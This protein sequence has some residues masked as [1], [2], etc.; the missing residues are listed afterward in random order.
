M[1][2]IEIKIVLV[3]HVNRIVEV[4]ALKEFTSKYFT[5]NKY[6][7]VANL[8]PP[9]KADGFLDIVY[10]KTE[11][12][13]LLENVSCAGICVGIMNYSFDDNF[14]M[15]RVGENKM[16][17]SLSKIDS[18]LLQKDISIENFIIKCIYEA[19]VLY[20][21]FGTLTDDRIY[22]FI[23]RDT[24]GCLFDLNGD[25]GDVIYN[26]E[27]PIICDECKSKI[28]RGSIPVGLIESIG[29]ELK[30]IHKPWVKSA[31]LFIK[32]YPLISIISTIIL[33]TLINLFSSYIWYS[34]MRAK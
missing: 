25:K 17:I 26:T 10:S 32:R 11:I 15:H 31:E 3:G 33:S 20:K 18:I 7:K 19:V 22:D 1:K 8:P 27:K 6:E 34:F 29:T 14:Y 4:N 24:R 21:I 2:K 16:C 13:R 5:I 28:N 23:H 12:T 30:R 9:K